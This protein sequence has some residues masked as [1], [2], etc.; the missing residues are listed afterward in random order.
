VPQA[1]IPAFAASFVSFSLLERDTA[2]FDQ[3]EKLKLEL[4][5]KYVVVNTDLPELK[6]FDGHVGQVKTVNMNGRALVEFNAWNNI[7]WYDID[8]HSLR[9]V[10]KPEPAVEGKKAEAPRAAAPPKAAAATPPAGEKKLSPLE[11]ARMQGAAKGAT[12]AKPAGD[13]SAPEKS[14][15][16][17]PGAKSTAD[18]LAAARAAKAPS[19]VG[20]KPAAAA[21]PK[22]ST[23]D[24]LAAARAKTPAAASEPPAAA[25]SAAPVAAPVAE[26]APTAAKAAPQAKP[27][28]AKT[29]LTPGQR[30]SVAEILVWCREHDA[31]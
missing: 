15:P 20:D 5:D 3:I 17:A 14:A 25:A 19:A 22:P 4:T 12:A 13:K 30:P 31:H 1:G 27:T 6:R 18:I 28:A 23:A 7:G 2:V 11:M 10:P 16:A 21:K 24:I 9:V 8:T 26:A 29:Q